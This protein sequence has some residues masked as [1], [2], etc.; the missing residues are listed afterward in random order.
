MYT[1]GARKRGRSSHLKIIIYCFSFQSFV[2]LQ[3]E[4]WQAAQFRLRMQEVRTWT[5]MATG[6]SPVDMHWY[7]KQTP[8]GLLLPSERLQFLTQ[9]LSWYT[10]V[11]GQVM[12]WCRGCLV[13]GLWGFFPFFAL[14]L[15]NEIFSSFLKNKLV[16]KLI[17]FCF[18]F[19]QSFIFNPIPFKL[20]FL[21]CY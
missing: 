4:S 9:L 1:S 10:W 13:W 2:N 21:F 11:I 8:P 6:C 14:L 16:N 7:P 5:T 19:T 15:E 18:Y 17:L 20:H 3:K 12:E